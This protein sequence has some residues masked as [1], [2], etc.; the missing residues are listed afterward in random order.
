MMMTRVSSLSGLL[1]IAGLSGCP[2]LLSDDF[3]L[4]DD[5]SDA[6][7]PTTE[8]L[9]TEPSDASSW[10]GDA[11]IE[12]GSSVPSSP[13][14]RPDAAAPGPEPSPPADAGV[15]EP[16]EGGADS[17]DVLPNLDAGL[18][19]GGSA[20]ADAGQAGPGTDAGHFGPDA[21]GG[22]D[23]PPPPPAPP[24]WCEPQA[25]A[26]PAAC[27]PACTGGCAGGICRITCR[28]GE[29]EEAILT[30]PPSQRCHFECDGEEACAGAYLACTNPHGCTVRCAGKK[31]CKETRVL[32][33]LPGCEAACGERLDCGGGSCEAQACRF[34]G[35]ARRARCDAGCECRLDDG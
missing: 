27:D 21:G 1:L 7:V 16:S 8:W 35:D 2:M 18:G 26:A 24:N 6:G 5:L 3:E 10:P 9:P 15:G 30:C 29:C 25:L 14:P 23:V 12:A 22:V 34:E 33:Q 13:D 17:G 31:A 20:G 28:A 19:S 32:C 4:D 11:G